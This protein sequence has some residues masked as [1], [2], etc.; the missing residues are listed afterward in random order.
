MAAKSI[1]PLEYDDI[2][3]IDWFLLF[4]WLSLWIHVRSVDPYEWSREETSPPHVYWLGSLFPNKPVSVLQAASCLYHCMP[5]ITVMYNLSFPIGL[6]SRL[7]FVNRF[8]AKGWRCVRSSSCCIVNVWEKPWDQSNRARV[9]LRFL[10]NLN[11]RNYCKQEN[12]RNT[13]HTK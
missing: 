12:T 11:R 6:Y 5:I 1:Q 13:S 4:P 10:S 9:K 3:T 7:G 8:R 2:N